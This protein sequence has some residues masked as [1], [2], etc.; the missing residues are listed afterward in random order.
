MGWRS[1]SIDLPWL[2]RK[3]TEFSQ[4]GEERLVRKPPLP[5]S[6]KE[7]WAIARDLEAASRLEAIRY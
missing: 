3:W 4:V 7:V 1:R 2:L 6:T 5:L